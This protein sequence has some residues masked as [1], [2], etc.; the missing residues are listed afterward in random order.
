MLYGVIV[1]V[2]A[3]GLVFLALFPRRP[4]LLIATSVVGGVVGLVLLLPTAIHRQCDFMDAVIDRCSGIYIGGIRLPQFM[5]GDHDD[6][7]L[8][9]TAA[10]IGATVADLIALGAIWVWSRFRRSNGIPE[11]TAG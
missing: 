10:L 7:W 8:L 2:F 5:Q 9:A 6:A 1:I 3:L 4:T 11:L